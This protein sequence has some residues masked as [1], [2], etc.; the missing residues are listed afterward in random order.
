MLSGIIVDCRYIEGDPKNSLVIPN[1]NHVQCKIRVC[2]DLEGREFLRVNGEKG[3]GL[4]LIV[5]LQYDGRSVF[6]S[7]VIFSHINEN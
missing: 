6:L 4:Q 7:L 2:G 1:S 5:F 3:E